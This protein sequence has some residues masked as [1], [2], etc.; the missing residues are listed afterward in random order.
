MWV[1]AAAVM[2]FPYPR[3]ELANFQTGIRGS[4]EQVTKPDQGTLNSVREL[5]YP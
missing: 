2:G 1:L 5:A 4:G 3:K